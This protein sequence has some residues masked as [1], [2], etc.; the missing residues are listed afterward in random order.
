MSRKAHGK[1]YYYSVD[2]IVN[3]RTGKKKDTSVTSVAEIVI[4]KIR[5]RRYLLN[6]NYLRNIQR[7]ETSMSSICN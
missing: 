6:Y 3:N 1:E 4:V 5:S 2:G 7:V